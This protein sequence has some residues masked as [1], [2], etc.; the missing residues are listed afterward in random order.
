MKIFL[1][2]KKNDI[3][4]ARFSEYFIQNITTIKYNNW[5]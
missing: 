4:N 3:P 5:G 2:K 1:R